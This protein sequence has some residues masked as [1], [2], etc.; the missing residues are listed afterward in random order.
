[1]QHFI[2]VF[3]GMKGQTLKK[4]TEQSHPQ[5]QQ[6]IP[7]VL[8]RN[9]ESLITKYIFWKDIINSRLDINEEGTKLEGRFL[10]FTLVSTGVEVGSK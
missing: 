6:N 10:E 8:K 5:L 4:G 7:Y 2:N 3:E 1:M 9:R